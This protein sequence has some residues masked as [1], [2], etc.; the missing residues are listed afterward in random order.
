MVPE[1]KPP[2]D[3]GAAEPRV[4]T[5]VPAEPGVPAA[6]AAPGIQTIVV[7]DD[8]QNKKLPTEDT[9][10]KPAVPPLE[11]AAVPPLE[12]A[13]LGN[14]APGSVAPGNVAPGNMDPITGKEKEGN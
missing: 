3:A 7:P 12:N 2:I 4:E 8:S 6:P 9:N 1:A 5:K 10:A 13:P 11:N 14:V